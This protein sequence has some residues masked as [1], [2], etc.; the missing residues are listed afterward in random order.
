M[1][2]FDSLTVC[3][4]KTDTKWESDYFQFVR[5]GFLTNQNEFN[6]YDRRSVLAENAKNHPP[7]SDTLFMRYNVWSI[8]VSVSWW[9]TWNSLCVDPEINH[10]HNLRWKLI[11]SSPT[12]ISDLYCWFLHNKWKKPY[13]MPSTPHLHHF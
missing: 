1:I 7:S 13:R 6:I 10:L 3:R 5:R 12:H 11:V 2:L 9:K 4:E 8:E